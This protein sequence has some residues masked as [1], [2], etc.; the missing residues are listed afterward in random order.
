MEAEATIKMYRY[1]NTARI[2]WIAI[3]ALGKHDY[4]LS[5][6]WLPMYILNTERL[7]TLRRSL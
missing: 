7:L 4:R 1:L 3:I 6:V 5:F 2:I